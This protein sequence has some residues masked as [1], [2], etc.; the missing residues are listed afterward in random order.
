MKGYRMMETP[1]AVDV[2]LIRDK[3]GAIRVGGT[4]VLLEVLIAA[5]QRGD[6]PEKIV[7]SFP[8]L[9][10]ADVYAVIAYYLSHR[11]EVDEYIQEVDEEGE[12][13]QQE[14]EARQA[15]LTREMLM[16]RIDKDR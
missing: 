11:D 3:D 10:L 4:R 5:H 7:A 15:P 13:I 1:T 6:P 2:P 14:W 9:K 8:T 12:R 16:A